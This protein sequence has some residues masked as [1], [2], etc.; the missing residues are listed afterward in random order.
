VASEEW[1]AGIAYCQL[2]SALE[3]ARNRLAVA[4]AAECKRTPPEKWKEYIRTERRLLRCLRQLRAETKVGPVTLQCWV[5][6]LDSLRD[7]VPSGRQPGS[8]AERVLLLLQRAL[9]Y[10]E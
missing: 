5:R 10:L 1:G 8:E 4:A 7:P 9:T 6:A 3:N 2:L